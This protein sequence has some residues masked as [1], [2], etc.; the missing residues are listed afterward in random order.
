MEMYLSLLIHLHV[1]V[2]KHR[3]NNTL[4]YRQY[5][6]H[7]I[8]IGS[9]RKSQSGRVAGQCRDM[10]RPRMHMK[11]VPLQDE[12]DA[13]RSTF[14]FLLPRVFKSQP[15]I[16]PHQEHNGLVR[17]SNINA[18]FHSSIVFGRST[19]ECRPGCPL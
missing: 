5:I 17:T 3:E 6:I 1:V 12:M 9:T 4:S 10:D 19:F 8:S 11:P 18:H 13:R 14:Q 15:T 2:L 7:E 16:H